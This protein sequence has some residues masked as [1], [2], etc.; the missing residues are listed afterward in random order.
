MTKYPIIHTPHVTV[1]TH[2]DK[3][4]HSLSFAIEGFTI[5]TLASKVK[6]MERLIAVAP[7]LLAVL[8][9][10]IDCGVA[11][12]KDDLSLEILTAIAKVEGKLK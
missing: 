12:K 6:K 7:T 2:E 11:D 5:E 8:K 9:K 4:P 1:I 3:T 10:C